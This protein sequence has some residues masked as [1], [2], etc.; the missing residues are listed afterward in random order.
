MTRI[1]E[2]PSIHHSSGRDLRRRWVAFGEG[3]EQGLDGEVVD[4]A[5]SGQEF[6]FGLQVFLG[7][8]DR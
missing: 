8:I 3:G 4:N 5:D 7:S 6:D 1:T 2:W